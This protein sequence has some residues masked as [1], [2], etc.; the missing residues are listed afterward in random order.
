VIAGRYRLEREIGRGGAGVVHLA[1]DEVLDRTVAIKRMGLLPGTTE[2]D[3][4]RAQREAR[5]AAGINHP[6]VV[7]VLDLVKDEDCYWLVME[8]VDGRT[9]SELV[10]T[11]GPLSP[12]RAAGLLA[13][14]ADGLVE[15]SRVGI[16]HRDVKPSNIM[17]DD[18]DRVT[19]G[20]FGIARAAN[21]AALTRTG[22]VTG[23]PAYLA[24]EVASG[25]QATAAS[26]VWSLGATLF[27]A[28]VGRAPYTMGQN[29]LGGLY[30]IVHDEPP[31]L[32]EDHPLAAVLAG[33]L[34]KDPHQR[35]SLVEVRDELRRVA[36]G[37]P[38][39]STQEGEDARAEATMVL[40]ARDTRD[41]LDTRDP[42]PPAGPVAAPTPGRDPR[43][44]R[45]GWVA[46]ALVLVLLAGLG[47]WLL[48]PGDG[49]DPDAT[50][51]TGQGRE[52]TAS[53]EPSASEEP[54]DEPSATEPTSDSTQQPTNEP[55][56]A[57]TRAS[58]QAFVQDYFSRVTSDPASTFALL[59]PQF[60]A[61]SGGFDGY[62]GFWSTIRTA[63]P[64]DIAAD[65][66]TLTVSYTI[67]YVTTSGRTTTQQGRLQLRRKGEGYLI[68]GE[69]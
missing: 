20:D 18:D 34:T 37:G 11:E 62:S 42:A 45:V 63:T 7:S 23:S 67:D 54:T 49:R 53:G 2:D 31:R 65:P 58:M 8:L 9:L 26:D 48:W 5:L 68:A 17:V 27:H 33:M 1:R 6:N 64:Y 44:S 56:P 47:A 30:K 13:Q 22:L 69:G 28:I 36:Q 21:D 29:V 46:A 4:A 15:A 3:V 52:P 39:A 57:G 12:T 43:R 10:A 14:A 19:L 25:E 16:V 61:Q 40:D 51:Q 59:T 32:P 60:Q 41:T 50:A 55:S 24:P 38:S 35:W 66:R